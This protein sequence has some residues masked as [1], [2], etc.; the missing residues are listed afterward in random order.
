MPVTM[1]QA[2]D[3]RATRHDDLVASGHQVDMVFKRGQ[4]ALSLRA[5]KIWHLLVKKA[6]AQL[7]D[8][9]AHRIELSELWALGHLSFEARL[10][11][12]R[13]LQMTI[14]EVTEWK[15]GQCGIASGPLLS[16]VWRPKDDQG[17]I[18]WRFS[19]ALK[20]IFANSDHWAILSKRAVMA[21]ESRY[22]LRLYEIVA[23]R[24]G[25]DHK[26]S[27]VFDLETLRDRFGV[28]VGKLATWNHF[29]LKALDPAIAEINQ[30]AGFN[31]G[32]EPVKKG[33][34]V[35]AVKL[36]WGEKSAPERKA[37]KRELDGHKVGRKARRMGQVEILAPPAQRAVSAVS[38]GFPRDGGIS[39]G[40][41]ADLAR[42]NLPYPTPDIEMVASAF[43]KWTAEKNL[44]LKVT[45][46]EKTF[47]SFCKKWKGSAR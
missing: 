27:E 29:H 33:R 16:Y 46:I 43:R 19:S 45:G 13:E 40:K 28:P 41:W 22:S 18:E 30:L 12:I 39:F 5:Q 8:E 26:T 10:D 11:A 47:V 31:V 38:K 21:F 32:Y 9:V 2:L 7:G 20:L 36:T 25:L 34:A 37:T 44:D 24:S 1:N 35:A 3:D 17:S 6:G 15:D 42:A 23:L 4:K 14:V